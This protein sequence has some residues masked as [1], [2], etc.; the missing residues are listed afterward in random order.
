MAC[1]C[2]AN[3]NQTNERE[4]C[5][6]AA[7]IARLPALVPHAPELRSAVRPLAV[8]SGTQGRG[9]STW[10]QRFGES[11]YPAGCWLPAWGEDADQ[12]I[13]GTCRCFFT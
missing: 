10:K 3:G 5:S 4:V 13:P 9:G 11:G 1:R 6:F 2:P 7:Y 12:L 8:L